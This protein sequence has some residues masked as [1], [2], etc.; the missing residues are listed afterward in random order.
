MARVQNG[1][2]ISLRVCYNF[3]CR[4]K[5]KK[6]KKNLQPAEQKHPVIVHKKTIQKDQHP[7][8]IEEVYGRFAAEYDSIHKRY[9]DELEKMRCTGEVDPAAIK[10]MGVLS[11]ELVRKGE[12]IKVLRAHETKVHE[13]LQE[14]IRPA[15]VRGLDKRTKTLELFEEMKRVHALIS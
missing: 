15:L 9:A 7:Q 13:Q 3:L 6:K 4:K 10:R 5:K 2:D 11:D 1:L 8:G 14:A 12:D